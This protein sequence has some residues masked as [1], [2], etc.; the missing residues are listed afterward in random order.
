MF[1]NKKNKKGKRYTQMTK[2]IITR[3]ICYK[4]V[5]HH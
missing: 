1:Y 2:I 3:D 4:N 5:D